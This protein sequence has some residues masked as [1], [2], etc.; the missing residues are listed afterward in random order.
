[1]YK[2]EG[3]GRMQRCNEQAH[4]VL[5][6]TAPSGHDAINSSLQ[7]LQED[8]NMLAAKMIETKV[9]IKLII[10]LYFKN[11]SCV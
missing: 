5:A 11:I 6:N 2:E 7:K 1:M 8:W 4:T 9:N 3:Y 10:V